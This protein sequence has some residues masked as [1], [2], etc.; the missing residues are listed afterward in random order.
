MDANDQ[1][2][3]QA[4]LA[5]EPAAAAEAEQWVARAALPF[6]RSLG[7]DWEAAVQD[8]LAGGLA[9][10]RSGRLAAEGTLRDHL[11]RATSRSCISRLRRR[12]GAASDGRT[13]IVPASAP[14]HPSS[15]LIAALA[16]DTADAEAA[17]HAHAHV[18]GCADCREELALAGATRSLGEGGA[19]SRSV[20]LAFTPPR[21]RFVWLPWTSAAVLGAVAAACLF[22]LV[23]AT[24]RAELS[25]AEREALVERLAVAED[26]ARG[27]REAEGRAAEAEQRASEL[28]TRLDELLQPSAGLAIVEL[29]PLT[30]TRGNEDLGVTVLEPVSGPF[31]LLRLRLEEPANSR[32]YEVGLLGPTGEGLWSASA[33]RPDATGALPLL[34]PVATLPPGLLVFEVETKPPDPTA[35]ALTYR[36]L[37]RPV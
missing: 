1:R 14:E 22:A 2:L 10:L 30:A 21:P 37:V 17:S 27:A 11:F 19:R 32:T 6:R 4:L 8:A 31:V 3:A 13:Q 9:A 28:Q 5:G 24:R 35:P 16:W 36:L 25:A 7:E 20:P 12:R 26:Q 18:E 29:V 23:S 33:V 34:L 15:D